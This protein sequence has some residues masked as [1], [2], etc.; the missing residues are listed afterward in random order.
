MPPVEILEVKAV[1]ASQ[2]RYRWRWLD[3]CI[4]GSTHPDSRGDHLVGPYPGEQ[5]LIPAQS[6]LDEVLGVKRGPDAL[7]GEGGR[8]DRVVDEP[9]P[10]IVPEMMIRIGRIKP[11]GR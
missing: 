7:L 10:V 8:V 6:R 11:D 9:G 2:V 5:Q 3:G 4:S 1:F